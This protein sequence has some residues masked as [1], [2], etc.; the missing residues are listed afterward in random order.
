M[1]EAVEPTPAE[2]TG[3]NQ[4]RRMRGR[5]VVE[6]VTED[7]EH[8]ALELD[9]RDFAELYRALHSWGVWFDR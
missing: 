5:G 1:S 8:L 6:F 4:G 7:G 2:F 3:A 9:Q